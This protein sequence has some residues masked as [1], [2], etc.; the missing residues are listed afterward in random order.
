[1]HSSD[2]IFDLIIVF[3]HVLQVNGKAYFVL[4]KIVAF[5]KN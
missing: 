4:N 1:M 5:F 2:H 3:N